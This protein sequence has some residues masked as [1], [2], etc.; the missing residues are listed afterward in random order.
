[1]SG[2]LPIH[3]HKIGKTDINNAFDLVWPPSKLA[4]TRPPII[5]TKAAFVAVLN[6]SRLSKYSAGARVVTAHMRLRGA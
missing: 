3:A 6:R 2:E 4:L 5:G 1:V